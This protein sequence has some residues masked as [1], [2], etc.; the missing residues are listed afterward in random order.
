MRLDARFGDHDWDIFDVERCARVNTPVVWVD[1]DS[2]TWGSPDDSLLGQI[3]RLI[4]G[5]TSTITHHEKRIRI[6][7]TSRMV[8]FNPLPD[9]D[10]RDSEELPV[11]RDVVEPKQGQRA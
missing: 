6:L 9:A 3:E 4:T 7:C 1:D 2:A 8:L 10:V 5:L 11:L